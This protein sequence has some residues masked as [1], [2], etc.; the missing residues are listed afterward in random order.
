MKTLISA[1]LI[2]GALPALAVN[3]TVNSSSVSISG[4]GSYRPD[5]LPSVS[6]GYQFSSVA[7]IDGPFIA[8]HSGSAVMP[9]PAGPSPVTTFGQSSAS[10]ESSTGIS[11]ISARGYVSSQAFS[12]SEELYFQNYSATA[13]SDSTFDVLFQLSEPALYHLAGSILK[14]WWSQ[15]ASSLSL[16]L[17]GS[18]PF[19]TFDLNTFIGFRSFDLSGTLDPG[20]YHLTASAH[21]DSRG[22]RT[23]SESNWASFDF[24]MNF[25][26]SAPANS[27]PEEGSTALLLGIGL[28]AMLATRY[29]KLPT[30]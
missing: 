26:P 27:V 13:S 12:S 1:L 20:I 25:E 9:I 4:R 11:Q 7:A 30:E 10:Q 21:S 28:L 6:T 2:V 19:L 18:D 23:W 8:S 17:L 24:T 22:S 5:G 14:Q 29:V 3:F 16:S 15:G